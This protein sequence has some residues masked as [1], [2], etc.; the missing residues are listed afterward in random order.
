MEL[1]RG[2]CGRTVG[3][4]PEVEYVRLT[5]PELGLILVPPEKLTRALCPRES[6]VPL[7]LPCPTSSTAFSSDFRL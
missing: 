4:D 6:P 5:E 2:L 1:V 7:P 3:A